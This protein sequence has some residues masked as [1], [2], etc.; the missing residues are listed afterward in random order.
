MSKVK[1]AQVLEPGQRGLDQVDRVLRAQ[2][3]AEDVVDA[4]ELEH[5]A[6]AAAGDG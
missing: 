2:R 3:L 1:I 4:G 5:G 6:H